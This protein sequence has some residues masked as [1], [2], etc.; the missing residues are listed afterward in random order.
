MVYQGIR[1]YSDGR[2]VVRIY[3]GTP[4]QPFD[5]CLD[6]GSSTLWIPDISC[7]R[8][9]M[10]NQFNSSQ[11]S[12]YRSTNGAWH[13][14]YLDGSNVT[15]I[16]GVDT[17]V[18]GDGSDKLVIPRTTFGQAIYENDLMVNETENTCVGL[19]GLGLRKTTAATPPL[20]DAMNQGII[21]DAIFTVYLKKRG[22]YDNVTGGRITY[23]D[24]DKT[25]CGPV[26]AYI[27]LTSTYFFI[28][29]LDSINFG[30]YI[31]NSSWQTIS[32][33]GSSYIIGPKHIVQ[34]LAK[35]AGVRYSN[36]TDNYY[37]DCD[38]DLPILNF[39]IGG[40]TYGIPSEQLIIDDGDGQCLW[41]VTSYSDGSTSSYEWTLG[42]P[43]IR[44]FCN[45]YDL[46]NKRIGFAQSKDS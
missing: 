10:Q 21:K 37:V 18:I 8:C 32:D 40:I 28:F 7:R 19:L 23:G 12:T 3:I 20:I 30:G 15:G 38:A 1:D 34:K 26:I 16:F 31:D 6:T 45:I 4:G 33:T 17:V 22:N 11:S 27:P 42:D 29:K 36:S 14:A 5:V 13:L 43:F 44:Q 35:E 41:A 9:S 46:G 25:N 2:Y 24:L 39:V